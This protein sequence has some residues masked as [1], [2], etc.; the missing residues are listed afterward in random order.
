[1]TRGKIEICIYISRDRKLRN[2]VKSHTGVYIQRQMTLINSMTLGKVKSILKMPFLIF[3]IL[4]KEVFTENTLCCV[5]CSS[6]V[7]LF[8][9]WIWC[10][11]ATYH[12]LSQYWPRS[13]SPCGVTRPQWVNSWPADAILC[14]RVWSALIQAMAYYLFVEMTSEKFGHSVIQ[15]TTS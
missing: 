5:P 14:H 10:P 9:R 1:M 11:L 12:Y 6:L 15:G 3:F 8:R 7:C 2:T 4:I 13:M